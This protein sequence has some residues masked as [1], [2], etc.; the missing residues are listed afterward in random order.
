MRIQALRQGD[1][2]G[3]R[4]EGRGVSREGEMGKEEGGEWGGGG[5]VR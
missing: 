4:R 1:G 5:R 3:R 2:G